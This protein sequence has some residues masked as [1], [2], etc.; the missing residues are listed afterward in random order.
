MA[1]ERA[2]APVVVVGPCAS[3]K[4]TLV[5]GLRSHG[6]EARVC[7]Q[8]HSAVASLWRHQGAALLIALTADLESVR[9]R[10]EARWPKAIHAAQLHRLA[11]AYANADLV[12]GTDGRSSGEVLSAALDFLAD[13]RTVCWGG[14]SPTDDP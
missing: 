9:T 8:E 12:I 4:S 11:D 5:R 13:P 7:A 6:Y 3:G 1:D 2:G 14:W 10:R